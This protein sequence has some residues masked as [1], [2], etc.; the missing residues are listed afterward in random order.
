MSRINKIFFAALIT[1]SLFIAGCDVMQNTVV[2]DT[3]GSNCTANLISRSVPTI[4]GFQVYYGHVHNHSAVSDGTGSPASAYAYAKN[5]AHLDFFSLAD[6]CSSITSSEWSSIKNAADAYNED[7]VFATLWGFEWSSSGSY[8]HITI[9][10]TTDY[11]TASSSATNTFIKLVSW[12]STRDGFAFFNHPGRENGSGKEFDHFTTAPSDKFVGMELW[13]KSDPFT[14]YYY[15]NGYYANDTNKSY[16]DEANGLGWKIGA[17]GSDDNHA[18]TWGTDNDYRLAILAN[19]LNRT[20]VLTA[21]KIRRFYSTLDKNLALSFTINGFEMGSTI[22]CGQLCAAIRASDQDGE[23]FTEVK[24]YNQDHSAV[25]A[26]SLN[27]ASVNLQDTLAVQTNDYYYVKVTQSDGNEAISSPIWISG[28]LSN[29]APSCAITAPADGA[30]LIAPA[31]ITLTASASDIDGSIRRVSFFQNGQF[32]GE[33]TTNPYSFTIGALVA[34]AYS[35]GASATDNSSAI[36]PVSTVSITVTDS[37]ANP[38]IIQ[39]H[40][41]AGMDDVEENKNGG[42][43]TNNS[44]LELVYDGSTIGNQTVGLRFT[45][46]LIPKKAKILCASLQ[47]TADEKKSGLTTVIIQGE[48]ADNSAAF[49]TANKNVSSRNKTTAS[50]SWQIPAWNTIG[51]AGSRQKTPDVKSVIQEIVNRDNYSVQSALV[52]IITGSG[53]RTAESYEGSASQ[54]PLLYV[55]YSIQ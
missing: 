6:H 43:L 2:I 25:A 3:D 15:N 34:G 48:A 20:E 11:C 40:I 30:T 21:L 42:V 39:R 26:W 22:P 19:A 37:S 17:A 51:A 35:L 41:A 54:S 14:V 27:T 55:E 45:G 10:N 13:N 12:L 46:M 52:I 33:D 7:G 49:T 16:F 28:G 23:N 1:L 8:G 31:P 32:L 29:Q 4:G 18:G 50:V 38:M 5:T 24:L 53:T 47:F 9:T 44:D 36:S